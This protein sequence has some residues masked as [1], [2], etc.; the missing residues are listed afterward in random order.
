MGRHLEVTS[1]GIVNRDMAGYRRRA[2]LKELAVQR[3]DTP[4]Q[5][6]DSGVT[7]IDRLAQVHG[8]FAALYD[9]VQA[10][11]TTENQFSVPDWPRTPCP[12]PRSVRVSKLTENCSR[13]L[14]SV[15]FDPNCITGIIRGLRRGPERMAELTVGLTGGWSDMSCTEAGMTGE[16]H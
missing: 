4:S 8:R 7:N 6:S 13:G 10:S 14:S 1:K 16:E 5:P 2:H 3:R 15:H 12:I 9:R 11:R